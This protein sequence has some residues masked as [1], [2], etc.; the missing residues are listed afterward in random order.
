MSD[1]VAL[2]C[3]SLTRVF[4]EGGLNVDVLRGV[5][6]RVGAGERIAIVGVSGSG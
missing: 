4:R 6:L 2:E 5:D 1:A 3:R